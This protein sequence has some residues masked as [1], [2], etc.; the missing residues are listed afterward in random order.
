TIASG[1][2]DVPYVE[3]LAGDVDEE[4]A[5]DAL[6]RLQGEFAESVDPSIADPLFREETFG[7]VTAQVLQRSP[8][9]VLAYAI[10]ETKLVI[11]DD[12]APIERLDS[13]DDSG[14]AGSEA[15]ES[16]TKDLSSEPSFITYLDLAGLVATAERLGAGSEGP[17]VAF[18]EDLRRL[19]TFAITV[20]TEEDVLSSD[21]LFRIAEP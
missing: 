7:D 11:A 15:Y 5:L 16:A 6:A 17:F 10:H 14:L 1:Q 9:D 3:F 20:G 18:A 4:A 8:G 12:T 2:T 13:D 21:A 19:Q